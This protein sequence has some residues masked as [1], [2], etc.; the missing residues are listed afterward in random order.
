MLIKGIRWLPPRSGPKKREY[1]CGRQNATWTLSSSLMSTLGGEQMAPNFLASCRECSHMLKRWD[2][3]NINK[4]FIRATNNWSLEWALRQKLW[5]SG[6]WD[7]ESPGRRS[8]GS[9]MKCISKR[10]YLAP[11]IWARVD[12]GPW[13]GNLCLGRVDVAEAGYHQAQRGSG[14]NHC[15]Y[16][17]TQ[18]P[19]QIPL[20]DPGKEWGPTWPGHPWS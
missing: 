12:G 11:T 13:S 14:G 17:A 4:P 18:P 19:D 5:L 10:G 2:G 16:F 7:S 3:K 9:I 15:K 8:K 20:Q 6:R 1:Q